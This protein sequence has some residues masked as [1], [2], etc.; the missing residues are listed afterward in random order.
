MDEKLPQDA[1]TPDAPGPDAS[2]QDVPAEEV[3][4]QDAAVA[5]LRAADPAA[6]VTV[7]AEQ[8]AA[9][10][11]AVE[12]RRTVGGTDE[13]APRRLRRLTSWP[14]RAAAAAAVALVVG[15]GGGYAL[16]AAGDGGL[17]DAAPTAAD[18][19]AVEDVGALGLPAPESASASG[20]GEAGAMDETRL[21]DG[22]WG[23]WF[24]RTVFSDGGLSDS[25][26]TGRAWALDASG[27]V[28]AD[29]VAEAAAALGV[30]G[31]ARLD[32]GSWVVGSADGV[33][34]TVSLSADG[35]GSFSY[36]NPEAESW[37]CD[38]DGECRQRDLGP[39]PSGDAAADVLREQMAA[40]GVDPADFD[41]VVE[42]TGDPAYAYV[43]AHHLVDGERTG[44]SWSASLTGAGITSLN[45]FTARLVD[46]GE[47]EVISPA[48]AVERL[49]DP[50]F[51]A[52]QGAVRA[53]EDGPVAYTEPTVEEPDGVPPAALTPGASF[54]WPVQ[55]VTITDARLALTLVAAPDGA[56]VLAP[57]Y[58]LTGDD[59]SV[60]SVL[61]V[62]DAH[63]VFDVD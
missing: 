41:V 29:A 25:P 34:A 48:A 23:G 46:L 11:A 31:E 35:T 7:S 45:G 49:N 3:A 21:A 61:A 33:G 1:P 30:E 32:F 13:L 4:A 18:A 60:W 52:G 12:Q 2:A 5:R 22:F 8:L 15:G 47:Y 14:A 42:D 10:R 36:W 20:L 24:G 63:L 53:L 56:T 59:G 54:T 26:G 50:R 38:G 58:E 40:L 37:A 43:V 55:R 6:A 44:L 39:A 17:G 19:G 27:T 9:L 62:A 16:G 51:G 57:S 28:S